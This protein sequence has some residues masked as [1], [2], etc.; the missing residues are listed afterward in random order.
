[1]ALYKLFWL[2]HN[3][4]WSEIHTETLPQCYDCPTKVAQSHWLFWWWAEFET[5]LLQVNTYHSGPAPPC[6]S[7]PTQNWTAECCTPSKT[8]SP[9]S[10]VHKISLELVTVPAQQHQHKYNATS[11]RIH[12]IWQCGLT[13]TC[14]SQRSYTVLNLV[15][16]GTGSH[17]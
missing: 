4:V 13:A 2:T 11:L 17:L 8:A 16:T 7:V 6:N 15:G 3:C 5:N 14:L 1:M 12:S 10:M 9:T